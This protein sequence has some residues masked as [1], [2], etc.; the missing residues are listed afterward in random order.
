MLP[1]LPQDATQI[2]SGLWQGGKPAPGSYKLDLIVFAA[3]EYQPPADQFPDV[4]TLYVP[5]EDS[6]QGLSLKSLHQAKTTAQILA[7]HITYDH[8]VLVTCLQGLNR[9]GFI[10][11]LTLIQLGMTP[12]D[13]I[14]L[15]REKR[16]EDALCNV[17]MIEQLG[18]EPFL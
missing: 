7:T 8:S 13:A 16:G 6:L 14:V 4:T 1:G 3:V 18:C 17:T 15:I 11:A 10:V 9:S 2:V 5:L 12:H